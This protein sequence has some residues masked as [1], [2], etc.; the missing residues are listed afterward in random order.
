MSGS[1]EYR[2]WCGMNERCHNQNCPGYKYYGSR[3]ITVCDEWRR[4]PGGFERFFAYMG[5][6]PPGMSI[7]RIRRLEGYKPG[8]VRWA[9]KKLQSDNRIVPSSAGGDGK[10][11]IP[12]GLKA[13]LRMVDDINSELE[14]AFGERVQAIDL[15]ELSGE[16]AFFERNY[17]GNNEHVE[18][19]LEVA[20]LLPKTGSWRFPF[21]P[22]PALPKPR[23]GRGNRTKGRRRRK[24]NR[25]QDCGSTEHNKMQCRRWRD[26]AID[27]A[28]EAA[29]AAAERAA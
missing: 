5:P 7:D 26:Q 18:G 22:N 15:S 16:L 19:I 3:G 24:A 23:L 12:F 2:T 27:R 6:R 20:D 11:M 8:N 29:A 1:P 14:R 17:C 13:T 28:Q 21:H 25:C 9:S 10:R 4:G